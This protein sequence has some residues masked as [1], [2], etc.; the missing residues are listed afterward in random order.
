PTEITPTT[1]TR[2]KTAQP[3]QAYPE[4]SDTQILTCR[5]RACSRCNRRPFPCQAW[6]P[7]SAQN[8]APDTY[9]ETAPVAVSPTRSP[10]SR[11]RKI[12][13]V[14]TIQAVRVRL[15]ALRRYF[16][17]RARLQAHRRPCRQ[18]RR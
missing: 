16:S 7:V 8:R 5:L 18:P 12:H 14:C 17:L 6:P 2:P 10:A 15:A 4:T 13:P 1:S 9:V 3:L 11:Q